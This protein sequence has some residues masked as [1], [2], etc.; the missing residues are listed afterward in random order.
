MKIPLSKKVIIISYAFIISCSSTTSNKEE[1]LK[2]KELELELKEKELML[3]QRELELNIRNEQTKNKYYIQNNKPNSDPLNFTK[4]DANSGTF[5][6]LKSTRIGFLMNYHTE[7]NFRGFCDIKFNDGFYLF[8]L[9]VCEGNY[10][11]CL[12]DKD[13]NEFAH[14]KLNFTSD[15]KFARIETKDA[16]FAELYRD[17]INILNRTIL[18]RTKT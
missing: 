17:Y 5:K 18:V 15:G 13:N 4:Y 6:P 2:I 1:A 16:E 3:N 10:A 11:W 9:P 14:M 12:R 8:I 7:E